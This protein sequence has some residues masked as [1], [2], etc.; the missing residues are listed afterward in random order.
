LATQAF[1]KG[2]RR[3]RISIKAEATLPSA[4]YLVYPNSGKHQMINTKQ[5]TNPPAYWQV[6]MTEI[7]NIKQNRFDYLKLLI[8]IYLVFDI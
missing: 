8:G 5:E 4:F 1:E 3:F 6:G 2:P 7:R